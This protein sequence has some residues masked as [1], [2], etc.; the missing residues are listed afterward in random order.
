MRKPA[1]KRGKGRPTIYRGKRT[2]TAVAK[3]AS[4]GLTMA[5]IAKSMG[6]GLTTLKDWREIHPEFAAA[7]KDGRDQTDDRVERSLYERAMGYSHDAV[8]VFFPS[9][10]KK[11]VYA[12]YVERYPPDPTS[13][14]F[15][16]KNRRPKDWRERQ[17]IEHSGSVEPIA[18]MTPEERRALIASL[19]AKRDAK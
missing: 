3:L 18:N 6:V 9:G 16:L 17:E 4:D 2:C 5:E 14:I 15:W 11:P 7:L 12:D 13:L 8:K 19:I 10:A 1:K